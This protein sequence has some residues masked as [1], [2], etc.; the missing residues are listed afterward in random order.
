MIM[1]IFS[2]MLA[3]A[4]ALS[5]YNA[6]AGCGKGRTVFSCMAKKSKR[7]EVCDLGKTI[8]YSFGKVGKPEIVIKVPRNRVT[9]FVSEGM[10][11]WRTGE[12]AINIPND[13]VV[14]QVFNEFAYFDGKFGGDNGGVRVKK[15]GKLLATVNCKVGKTKSRIKETKLKTVD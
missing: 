6:Y 12:H 1:K 8:K 13:N 2:K 15:K 7:I 4:V 9:K 3:V 5:S 14:Y 11:R 10:G